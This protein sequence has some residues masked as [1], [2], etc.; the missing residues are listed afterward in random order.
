MRSSG[1]KENIEKATDWQGSVCLAHILS[2]YL[3]TYL[4]RAWAW[5]VMGRLYKDLCWCMIATSHSCNEVALRYAQ[6]TT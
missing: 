2:T 5:M 1:N 3:S 6:L 4:I